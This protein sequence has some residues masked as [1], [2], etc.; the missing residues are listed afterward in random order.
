MEKEIVGKDCR[1]KILIALAALLLAASCGGKSNESGELVALERACAQ[2]KW[3]PIAVEGYLAA[4]ATSCKKNKKGSI[5]G[6]TFLL[7]ANGDWRGASIPVYISSGG[8]FDSKN[9]TL[10]DKGEIFDNDANP[11]PPNSKIRIHGTLP[12]SEVCEI[13]LANRIDRV[14]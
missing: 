2:E 1:L 5:L 4:N 12:K 14:S 9:N 8:A 10:G 6:C 11:I 3:K 13:S 7:H